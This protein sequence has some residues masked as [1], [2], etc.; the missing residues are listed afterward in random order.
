MMKR[1]PAAKLG[2]CAELLLVAAGAMLSAAPSALAQ[3]SQSLINAPEPS[4]VPRGHALPD[5]LGDKPSQPPA[6]KVAVEP[7]GFSA[8]AAFYF[9][10]NISFVSL[11]FL[12]E[13]R[14]LFTFRV[15]GLL[16]REAGESDERQIR[17]VVLTLPSG[18]VEAEAV[19]TV[20][21]RSRYLWM[22]KDGRF[23]LR[24]R[25][26]LEQGDA[27][28][29]LK[30]FLHFPGP[31]LSLEMDPAQKFLVTNSREPMAAAKPGVASPSSSDEGYSLKPPSAADLAV[32]I[33]RRESGQVMLVSRIHSAVHLPINSDG[34]LESL[35]GTGDQWL[36][37]LNYFN[38]GS[39]ILG[40]VES[41]CSPL[42]DFLSQREVLITTCASTGTNRLIAMGLDG[43]RLWEAQTSDTTV[44][45]LVV[46]SPDGSRLAREALSVTHP[47][48]ARSPLSQDEI[49]GQLVEVL[50]AADGKVE[51]E[52]Q[53]SPVLDA[54]GNVAISPSGRRVA[55]L[56]GGAIQVFELA[57]LP[58]TAA[59]SPGR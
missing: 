57:P 4:R 37:N 32:R 41:T 6:F 19:W 34:Y 45:A 43:R 18:A 52:A 2:M 15:P 40:R 17:A 47:V 24:D 10:L 39:H 44:W 21:D 16:H 53:A 51:L 20:H 56:N 12:D 1:L 54:G 28:L 30:P 31:V 8:P 27:A 14:L 48:N 22:L 29:T 33:L 46:R 59:S 13:N 11:D 9:G 26:R 49:K 25:D 42:F 35:R 7:L 58:A 3:D 50:D 36:L 23:L 55:V 5:R 38:G